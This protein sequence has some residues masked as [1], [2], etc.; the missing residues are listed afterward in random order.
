MRSIIEPVVVV[1]FAVALLAAC[2]DPPPAP[3][4]VIL[5]DDPATASGAAPTGVP[6]I[7]AAAPPAVEPELPRHSEP[8]PGPGPVPEPA[9]LPEFEAAP[10]LEP[11]PAE[12]SEEEPAPECVPVE[13]EDVPPLPF[14]T[15][16]PT[17]LAHGMGGFDAFGPLQY[18]VDV[19][20]ALA[21][22][23]YAAYTAVVEPLNGTDVRAPQLAAFIDR[24]LE[25]T[26]A[27][28]V[29]LICHSQGGIDAR[30]VMNVLGYG[31]RIESITTLA[32][33]HQGSKIADV[34]LGLVPGELD[35]LVNMLSWMVSEIYTDPKEDV[36]MREA[37]TWVST[38]FLAQFAEDYPDDP[39]VARYSYGGR[40]GLS[41]DGKPEC[42]GYALP[43]PKKKAPMHSPFLPGWTVL[44]GLTGVANDGMVA[45]ESAKW[46]EF[47]GCV[48][49]DHIQEIGLFVL[50]PKVHDHIG[51]FLDHM[52]F[53]AAQGH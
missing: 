50:S 34:L 25:C 39:T 46:G 11:V 22:E 24:V 17:V 48:P 44:G 36:L 6:E 40:A 15:T 18:W 19:E 3:N 20:E 7:E 4:V 42:E 32:T 2:S 5:D 28:R 10:D 21:S 35:G 16:F 12:G 53:L 45:V 52:E 43:N 30:Y 51:F 47:R 38:D 41:G 27:E 49:A 29:N 14:G 37:L 23:G 13:C 1:L 31:D 33:P 8:G 9:S 26:C